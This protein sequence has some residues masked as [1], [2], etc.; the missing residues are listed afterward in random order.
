MIGTVD[1]GHLDIHNREPGQNAIVRGLL[2]ALVDGGD[3]FTGNNAAL[4][5]IDKFVA[6]S[7]LLRLDLK[8]DMTD[9]GRDRRTDERTCLRP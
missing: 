4:D 8:P 5:R 1:Q 9:T 2:N 7:S 3:I 6:F